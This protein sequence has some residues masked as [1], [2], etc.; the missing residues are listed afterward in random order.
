MAILK[1][2]VEVRLLNAT[3]NAAEA[4]VNCEII[5]P[6]GKSLKQISGSEKLKRRI[7]KAP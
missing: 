2:H 5:S 7:D 3:A 6:D 1:S 4:A